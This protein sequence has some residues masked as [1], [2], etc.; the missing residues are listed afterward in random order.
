MVDSGR[1]KSSTGSKT[2]GRAGQASESVPNYKRLEEL[3][4]IM[5]Q[6]H[7][8]RREEVK[9][10]SLDADLEPYKCSICQQIVKSA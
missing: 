3:K 10:L 8:K 5:G 1:P 4:E 2:G 9:L 7:G 6:R